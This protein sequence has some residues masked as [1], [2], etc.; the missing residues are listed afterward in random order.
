M[1]LINQINNVHV[2][3]SVNFPSKSSNGFGNHWHWAKM[4]FSFHLLSLCVC[5]SA[6]KYFPSTWSQSSRV[7][8]KIN[9]C[10]FRPYV[11]QQKTRTDRHTY[12]RV[13]LCVYLAKMYKSLLKKWDDKTLLNI[14]VFLLLKHHLYF[15][16]PSYA[17]SFTLFRQLHIA[18]CLVCAMLNKIYIFD[19]FPA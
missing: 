11:T 19:T 16:C 10:V 3:Y 15:K 7:Q 5:V 4:R 13:C 8:C 2:D 18:I 1:H 14:A 6:P 17:Q 9:Y 12:M